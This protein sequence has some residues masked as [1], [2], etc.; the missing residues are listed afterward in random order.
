MGSK[1][2]EGAKGASLAF[3][4]L[5][6]EHGAKVMDDCCWRETGEG[7]PELIPIEL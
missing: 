4:S 1:A 2:R 3:A 5:S 6:N 7:E